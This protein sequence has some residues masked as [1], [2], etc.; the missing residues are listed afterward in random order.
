[1]DNN[2]ETTEHSTEAMKGPKIIE[3]Q[4]LIM[5]SGG[6]PIRLGKSVNDKQL[7]LSVAN[8][9]FSPHPEE[10][11]FLQKPT[12]DPSAAPKGPVNGIAFINMYSGDE[13][14]LK[15][16][17]RYYWFLRGD[18]AYGGPHAFQQ[19]YLSDVGIEQ[20]EELKKSFEWWENSF[21]TTKVEEEYRG[22][23]IGSF[24]LAASL[25]NLD[26]LGFKKF[27]A[28]NLTPD[29]KKL[30]SK[31]WTW[32]KVIYESGGSVRPD[33]SDVTIQDLLKKPVT[34]QSIREFI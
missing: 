25:A 14:D 28:W 19:K 1:M 4:K 9:R 20:S 16:I 6:K 15:P 11:E 8:Q 23:K 33:S 30:W 10:I 12:Y 31:F 13:A 32:D 22:Q 18:T 17:G 29:A 27:D 3:L 7:Y 34:E 21:T 2:F 5:V 24:M 26:M